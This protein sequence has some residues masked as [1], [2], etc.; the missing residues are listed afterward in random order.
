MEI[1]IFNILLENSTEKITFYSPKTGSLTKYFRIAK[2]ND[3]RLLNIKEFCD[4]V[5]TLSDVKTGK[6]DTDDIIIPEVI[7]PVEEPK[8]PSQEEL[9][10]KVITD[11]ESE[12][13]ALSNEVKEII[14][15]LKE[16]KEI[17]E[18]AK[19]TANE[20]DITTKVDKIDTKFNEYKEKYTL[21]Q[22]K[23]AELSTLKEEFKIAYPESMLI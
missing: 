10:R 1:E 9:D 5:I 19:L 6:F 4:S 2:D 18:I 17:V 23:K 15:G 12:V 8:E 16:D 3:E 20:D 14:L 22:T 7:T 11:K 13:S 21:L